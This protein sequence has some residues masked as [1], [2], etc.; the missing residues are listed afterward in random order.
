MFD[1]ILFIY[2]NRL[3]KNNTIKV[4]MNS[5]NKKWYACW[6]RNGSVNCT[7][8]CI[9]FIEAERFLNNRRKEGAI[10]SLVECNY[11]PKLFYGHVLATIKA[12]E[13]MEK[14]N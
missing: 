12:R 1:S 11:I 4:K 7:K 13:Q 9:E 10:T 2:K 8:I 3:K 14:C 6:K 5:E